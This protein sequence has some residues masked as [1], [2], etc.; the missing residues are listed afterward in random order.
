LLLRRIPRR[1]AASARGP[2]IAQEKKVNEHHQRAQQ[3]SLSPAKTALLEQRLRGEPARGAVPAIEPGP[4]GDPEVLASGQERLWFLHQLDPSSPAYNM[5]RAVRISGPLDGALLERSVGEVIHRHQVL[6]TTFATRDGR[7]TPVVAS[8]AV[9]DM[10]RID[11]GSLPQEDR[12]ARAREHATEEVSRPFELGT[13]P[14][15]RVLLLRLGE[16]EHVLLV[17]MHHIV[18]DEWSLDLFWR[19]LA[20]I[21]RGLCSGERIV[22]P[23]LPI[24]YSDYAKWQRGRLR[25]TELQRHLGYWREKLKGA[26]PSPRLPTDS[27]QPGPQSF[28]GGLE[29]VTLSSLSL[30]R[31]QTLRARQGVTSFVLL[32]AAFKTLLYRYSGDSDIVVGAP[33]TTRSRPELE[34]LIGFFINTLCLRSDLSGHPSF[35]EVISRVRATVLDAFAHQEVPFETVVDE[36]K[37][38]RRVSR[39]P[40]FQTMFVLQAE[41]VTAAF[42]AELRVRPFAVEAAA[43]KF[44]LTLFAEELSDGLKLTFE[45]RTDLF[46]RDTVCRMLEHLRVLLDAVVE[47]PVR[48]ISDLPLLPRSEQQRLLFEWNPASPRDS[49]DLCMHEWLQE[50]AERTPEAVAVWSEGGDLTY[51][52]L[53]A[54]A[55]AIADHLR[56]LGVRPGTCVGLCL[57]RSPEMLV[58]IV[59]VLKAGGA[60]VPLDPAYPD[61]RLRYALEDSGAP[62]VLTRPGLAERLPGSIARVI[63]IAEAMRTGATRTYALARSTPDDPAYVIYT[64][65][66]TGRPKGVPVTH[67]NLVHS[68][69]ARMSFY[70]ERPERFLLL[71]SFAFDSSVAGIFWTLGTG[72]TLVL[73]R[74]RSEQDVQALAE[75]IERRGVTH[76]LCLPT[77]YDLIREHAH[78]SQLASLRTVIVAGEACPATLPRRHYERIPGARLFNEYGPTEATVWSTAYEVPPEFAGTQVPIGR[79]V[80]DTRVY[81]LDPRRRLVPI[82]VR[83]ELYLGGS[84]I[85]PGYLHRPE[86]TAERFVPDPF[87][88]AA[89]ARLYRTGDLV[90]WRADGNLEFLGRT[91][92]QLK[93]R[94]YRIEPGEIEAALG[95]HPGVRES[96]VSTRGQASARHPPGE[97]PEVDAL[98]EALL[99]L[100]R[101]EAERILRQVERSTPPAVPLR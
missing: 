16:T 22:L 63:P 39:N 3:I 26:P 53:N 42:P 33:V 89:G 84:G 14:L 5:F 13:P 18:S 11:L 93:I 98:A 4:A 27:P 52:E 90:R 55:D 62:V 87:S 19:E 67:R 73:P 43:A 100:P 21:Y 83:G 79:P 40:L 48:P 78:P 86:E 56:G 50:Q 81:V 82:G 15:L 69:R 88:A 12:E 85:T 80:G 28:R 76:L 72:G 38:D 20:S 75:L 9:L 101:D 35:L 49:A 91:D 68:T 8:E 96:V 60:Y 17:T 23:E 59:G 30:G 29:S 61:A 70:V 46:S 6:R 77:L 44:D 32:L 66:S 58:G 31:L 71:P 99:S 92:H 57:E 65:G 64:S 94:G 25:G 7:P 36:L 74:E 95:E 24:Q 47:D 34:P 45:Y 37:P 51:G 54:R 2:T 1:T 97:V 10:R 41:P